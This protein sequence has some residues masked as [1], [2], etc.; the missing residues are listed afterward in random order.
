[1]V[2]YGII[3]IAFRFESN[4]EVAVQKKFSKTALGAGSSTLNARGKSC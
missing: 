1:M 3:M 2:E 4:S